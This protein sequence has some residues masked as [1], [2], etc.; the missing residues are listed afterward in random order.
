[1]HERLVWVTDPHL[2]HVALPAWQRL[3]DAV[4]SRQPDA[5]LITG[6]ISEGDDVVFQLRRLAEAVEVPIYFILGN[7]D[8]Y[9]SSIARTRGQV[10]DACREDPRLHYLTDC[11]PIEVGGGMFLAGDDG[12]GDATIGDYEH[13]PIKLNDFDLIEDFSRS[14]PA[15]WKAMLTEQGA[16]S[17]ERLAE[18]LRSLAVAA[19]HVVILTHV[20]PFRESCWYE[21]QTTDDNWA[22]FFVCGCVGDALLAAAEARP[23][24]KFTVLCG[25]THHQG[26]SQIRDN[27]IVYTGAAQYGSPE[28]EGTIQVSADGCE[29]TK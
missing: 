9:Q 5:L 15:N 7:H 26:V 1:M 19:H 18:K 16:A 25:H 3:I 4:R 22:P 13:T 6:D 24:V 21:G 23:D 28:V 11:R 27:L 17:A 14:D 12:W 2:N 20:P 10:I 8:F 29:I